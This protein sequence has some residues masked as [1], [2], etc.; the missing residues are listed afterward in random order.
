[1]D[2]LLW[3]TLGAFDLVHSSYW[4]I[5]AILLCGKHS[6]KMQTW[7]VSRLLLQE[8]LKTQNQHQEG[9]CVFPEVTRLCQWV[10]CARNR[11]QFHTVLQ[12]LKSFLSM[13]FYAWTVF[14]LSLSGIKWLKY[15]IPYRTEL[16]GPKRECYGETRQQL[17][18]QTCITQAHQSTPTS[19]QQTLIT[20]H[21]IQRILVLVLC[22]VSL[23]TMRR[24]SKWL[25]KVE[26]PEWDMFHEPT[27]LLWIGCFTGWIWTH[28]FKS[29]TLTPNTNSQTCWLKGVSRVMSGIIFFICWI[30]A[31]SAP[32][33][34]PRISA[35]L[36]AP[37]WR[38]G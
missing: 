16:K 37:R 24:K 2:K 13:Q 11:L 23:R 14:P 7:I 18:S 8:T 4:W 35:W 36:A 10:G 5:P 15:F 19:F 9:S 12:K 22:C 27:E 34:A 26:V 28:K 32:L 3:K 21:Q 31:I 25:S 33:A 17:S 38:R 1:M 20:F 6:T 29:V 30:S